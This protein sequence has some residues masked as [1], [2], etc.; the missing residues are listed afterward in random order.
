MRIPPRFE[1]EGR[2]GKVCRLKKSLYGI[3]QSP[4]TWFKRFSTTLNQLEYKQGQSDYT[5]F[6]KHTANGQ[7]TIL[8]VYVDDT[9]I[10][11]DNM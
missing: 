2:V 1:M 9:I 3:K 11:G 4:R 10:T 8:I 7:K 5:L 6:T